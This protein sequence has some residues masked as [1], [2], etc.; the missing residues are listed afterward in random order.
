MMTF[1]NWVP[2]VLEVPPQL[3]KASAAMEVVVVAMVTFAQPQ[4]TEQLQYTPSTDRQ[5]IYIN[6]GINNRKRW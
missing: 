2:R 1:L 3:R 6:L 5:T 4:Q